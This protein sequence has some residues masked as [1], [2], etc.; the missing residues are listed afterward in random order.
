M[1]RQ[2][3]PLCT[4]QWF[5]NYVAETWWSGLLIDI[6][7]DSWYC[8]DDECFIAWAFGKVS[9]TIK[10]CTCMGFSAHTQAHTYIVDYLPR[11]DAR[12]WTWRVGGG[13]GCGGCAGR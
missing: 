11:Q 4:T 5:M 6:L 3:S 12:P 2:M 8:E 9:N 7:L 13:G 10:Y 1:D